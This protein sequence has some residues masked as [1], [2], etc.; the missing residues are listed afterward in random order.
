M[1]RF[2]IGDKIEFVRTSA[3]T[4]R[5]VDIIQ[6]GI[7]KTEC[8]RV[9]NVDHYQVEWYWT[10]DGIQWKNTM[11]DLICDLVSKKYRYRHL[12]N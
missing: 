6:K 9:D 7:V 1:A 4:D 8:I 5:V 12:E 11:N 3:G 10:N 2:N